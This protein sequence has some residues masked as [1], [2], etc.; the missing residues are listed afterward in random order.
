LKYATANNGSVDVP[1]AS[2]S[3][4]IAPDEVEHAMLKLLSEGR[5]RLVK[6]ADG[7]T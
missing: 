7:S 3:L 4:G 6:V 1:N 5:V 2:N